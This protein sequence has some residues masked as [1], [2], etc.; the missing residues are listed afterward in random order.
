MPSSIAALAFAII[1]L[2]TVLAAAAKTARLNRETQ[3]HWKAAEANWA[4][5]AEL[6]QQAAADWERVAE[7]QQLAAAA[8]AAAILRKPN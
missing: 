1:T 7:L 2:A 6:Q 5:V 8:R 3:A 4:R